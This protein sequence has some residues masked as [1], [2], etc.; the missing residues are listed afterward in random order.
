LW[1]H[2]EKEKKNKE[3][4][5]KE[6]N[7]KTRQTIPTHPTKGNKAGEKHTPRER[8]REERT[9]SYWVMIDPRVEMAFFTSS[10][11]PAENLNTGE[12]EACLGNWSVSRVSF[13]ACTLFKSQKQRRERRNVGRLDTTPHKDRQTYITL[14]P[15]CGYQQFQRGFLG[16]EVPW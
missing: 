7:T 13:L 8:E 9:G 2:G 3:G 6:T 12:T 1:I 11:L 14:L 15:S 10:T 5:N 4:T 16:Q